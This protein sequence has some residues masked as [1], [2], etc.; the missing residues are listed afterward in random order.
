M[1][2]FSAGK[3]GAACTGHTCATGFAVAQPML[4][5]PSNTQIKEAKMPF[6]LF[7]TRLLCK[8]TLPVMPYLRMFG[9]KKA[10]TDA[11]IVSP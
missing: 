2:L 1:G 9:Q 10:A 3:D 11:A 8:R 6:R 5:E 7:M 4:R